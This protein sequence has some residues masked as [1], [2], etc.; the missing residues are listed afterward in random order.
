MLFVYTYYWKF[1]IYLSFSYSALSD[2]SSD[3]MAEAFN[4]AEVFE[5]EEVDTTG[6]KV[7]VGVLGALL[8]IGLIAGVGIFVYQK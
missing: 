4:D 8:G 2:A 3:I 1:F 7:A 5:V 6:L